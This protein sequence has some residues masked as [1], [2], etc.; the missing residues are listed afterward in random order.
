MAKKKNAPKAT[1]K[2]PDKEFSTT[3]ILELSEEK[4]A[5][6]KK[7]FHRWWAKYPFR[8]GFFYADVISFNRPDWPTIVAPPE[9]EIEIVSRV[10]DTLPGNDDCIEK[11][12]TFLRRRCNVSDI[13]NETWKSIVSQCRYEEHTL[14]EET[15][16]SPNRVGYLTKGV[17]LREACVVIC[18]HDPEETMAMKKRLQKRGDIPSPIG[19]DIK[20]CQTNLYEPAPL[21]DFIENVEGYFPGPKSIVLKRLTDMSRPP[22]K[23]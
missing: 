23:K 12:K 5:V 21:L 8:V 7:V 13:T 3:N 15:V 18:D 11:A 1:R 10:L 4:Q 19:K 16:T 22:R 6:L 14:R 20:H 17:S 2:K 9:E